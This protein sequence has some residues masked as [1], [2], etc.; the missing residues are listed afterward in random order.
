VA[1]VIGRSF[2]YRILS[3]VAAT[4]D[5]DN[6]LD[7]LK[8]IQLIRERR[9]VKEIEYLF[10]HALAQEAAY[11]SILVQKRKAIHLKVAQSIETIFKERL[12]EFYGMLAFHYS[13]GEDAEKT[14]EYLIK[15]GEEALKS[16]GSS[17]ALHYYQEALG[18]YLKKFGD[19]ADPEKVAMIQKNIAYAYYNRGQL[20]EALA[21]FDKV[22][23]FYGV[24]ANRVS[25][26]GLFKLLYRFL[27][28]LSALYTPFIRGKKPPSDR[29]R[30][31]IRLLFDRDECLTVFDNKRFFLEYIINSNLFIPFDLSSVKKGPE[32]FMGLSATFS[33]GG[34]SFR[35]SKKILMLVKENVNRNDPYYVLFYELC[36]VLHD[37]LSGDWKFSI[38]YDDDLV[39]QNLKNIGVLI[40]AYLSFYVRKR[41][42]RGSYAGAKELVTKLAEIGNVYEHELSMVQKYREKTILLIKWGKIREAWSRQRR[43][44]NLFIKQT[45]IG[46]CFTCI[47]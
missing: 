7:Y 40:L 15:A 25:I 3:E 38:E 2:F 1:S 27:Y 9:R 13:K 45:M 11:E 10:K 18:L 28:L 39:N 32:K 26:S 12:R 31:I 35:L 23:A 16:S 17:E 44:S 33:Y 24:K 43:G 5:M 6:R 37:C 36:A 29:D 30:E 20:G 14:E 8:T 22:L 4:D 19:T 21:Y 41:I 46:I 42:E 47:P 34:L